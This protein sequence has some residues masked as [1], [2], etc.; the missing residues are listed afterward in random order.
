MSQQITVRVDDKLVERA[1]Q[2]LDYVTDIIGQRAVRA[3]VW[4]RALVVGLAL[5]EHERRRPHR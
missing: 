1:D 4:R 3:D 2:L 5:L